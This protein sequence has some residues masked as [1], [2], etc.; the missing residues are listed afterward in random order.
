MKRVKEGKR[1]PGG[2]DPESGKDGEWVGIGTG[3]IIRMKVMDQEDAYRCSSNLQ[4]SLMKD[5]GA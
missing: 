4:G 1:P 3:P 5:R 2:S